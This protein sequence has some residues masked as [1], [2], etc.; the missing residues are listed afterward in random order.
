M[1]LGVVQKSCFGN[2]VFVDESNGYESACLNTVPYE[3]L[4]WES[5]TGQI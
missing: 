3:K 1:L 2:K 4:S 5:K